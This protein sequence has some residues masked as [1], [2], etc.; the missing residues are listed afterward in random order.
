MRTMGGV[1]IS[2]PT[3]TTMLAMW[4]RSRAF[5]VLKHIF[6]HLLLLCGEPGCETTCPVVSGIEPASTHNGSLFQPVHT[7]VTIYCTFTP[8]EG[9]GDVGVFLEPLVKLVKSLP[10]MLL[11]ARE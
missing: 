10:L 1:I 4:T 3:T 8:L 11:R 6:C 7:M 9:L 5:R 2:G